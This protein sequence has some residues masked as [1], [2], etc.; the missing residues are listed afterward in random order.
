[1]KL[2][3]WKNL[4]SKCLPQRKKLHNE[5]NNLKFIKIYKEHWK[6]R[7]SREGGKKKKKKIQEKKKSKGTGKK[8]TCIM[9]CTNCL[10]LP[11]I[12]FFSCVAASAL[13]LLSGWNSQI[14]QTQQPTDQFY[15]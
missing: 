8:E 5:K 10:F 13:T 9:Y 4:N 14:T 11:C 1:M 6:K 12:I 7:N 3:K 15:I 2:K